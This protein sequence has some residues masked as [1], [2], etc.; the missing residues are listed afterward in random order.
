MADIPVVLL[1]FSIVDFRIVDISCVLFAFASDTTR[2]VYI[3]CV[4][5]VFVIF[6]I[7][8]HFG[9]PY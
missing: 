2:I 3:C 7:Y 9:V 5:F 4:L 8:F 1:T 6:V